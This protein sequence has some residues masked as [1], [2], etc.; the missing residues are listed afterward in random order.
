LRQ[1][2]AGHEKVEALIEERN[3]DS[4]IHRLDR[5]EQHAFLRPKKRKKKIKG[6]GGDLPTPYLNRLR[7]RMRE[8]GEELTYD[9]IKLQ[10]RGEGNTRME[11]EK[12]VAPRKTATRKGSEKRDS[13]G[14]GVPEGGAK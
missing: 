6:E 7:E 10:T 12:W 4:R 2:K 8:R 5:R 14:V 1:P 9:M 11:R 13:G 3:T